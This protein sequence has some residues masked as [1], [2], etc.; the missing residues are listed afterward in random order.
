MPSA[1]TAPAA[2]MLQVPAGHDSS[3]EQQ[4]TNGYDQ[5]E[6]IGQG[7]EENSNCIAGRGWTCEGYVAN[8]WCLSGIGC[9]ALGHIAGFCG[10]G[11]GW[12]NPEKHC[13][14]CQQLPF[15][16]TNGDTQ[17]KSSSASVDDNCIDGQ[18]WT[19]KGY[20][21]ND[22]CR[23]GEGCTKLGRSSGNC[24]AG[25]GKWNNPEQHCNVCREPARKWTNGYG[26]CKKSTNSEGDNC[27][28]G[29][30]WTCEGYQANGWCTRGEGCTALGRN[31]GICGSASATAWNNP[32]QNCDACHSSR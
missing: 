4:W 25:T 5:C 26:L 32:D 14:A 19:C 6:K 1:P 11:S 16:W 21:A 10:V 30:G 8:E 17:C 13:S 7:H 31:L 18:G 27:I 15:R 9:T 24:G 29:H 20:V 3:R 12:K 28:A 23:S 2:A 22:W